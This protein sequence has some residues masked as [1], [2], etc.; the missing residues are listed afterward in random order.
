[1][2]K[3]RK[4]MLLTLLVLVLLCSYFVSSAAESKGSIRIS[5]T[6]GAEGTSKEGVVLGYCKVEGVDLDEIKNTQE[7]VGLSEKLS[8]EL[9]PKGMVTTDTNGVAEIL[10]LEP[11]AYLIKPVDMANYDEITPTLVSIPYWNNETKEM[12]YDIT[13]IPKHT[14]IFKPLSKSKAVSVVPEIVQTGDDTHPW[15]YVIGMVIGASVVA[16]FYNI[17]RKT[18]GKKRDKTLHI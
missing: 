8:K 9:H 14:P 10:G 17:K 5:L 6:D 15:V 12:L 13:V 1:M 18:F 3:K 11:G 2:N 16:I 4:D 7:L